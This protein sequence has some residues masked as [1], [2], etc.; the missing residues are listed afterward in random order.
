M[1]LDDPGVRRLLPRLSR[2]L[3][4]YGLS[5]QADVHAKNPRFSTSGAT[6]RV[7]KGGREVGELRLPLPGR[8]MLANALGATTAARRPDDTLTS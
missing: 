4:T 1:C 5:P 3:V 8:H 6:C 2:R 7:V